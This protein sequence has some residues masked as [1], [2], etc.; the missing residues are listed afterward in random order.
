M[1]IKFALNLFVFLFA[2]NKLYAQN[3]GIGTTAPTNRVHV[4]SNLSNDLAISPAILVENINSS[5]GEAGVA[6]KNAGILGTNN[7]SWFIGL[8]Q[9]RNFA[10]SYGTAFLNSGTKMLLDSTGSLGLGTINPDNSAV[11]DLVSVDKGLLLPRLTDTDVV[12]VPTAGLVMYNQATKSP[13]YYDGT[14]WNNLNGGKNIVPLQGSITYTITGTTNVGGITVDAGPLAAIDYNNISFAARSSG[15]GASKAENVDS[16]IIFKEFDANSIV[17][18]RAHIGGNVLQVM[19]ISQFLPGAATP[20]Y[21]VKLTSFTVKSH[22]YFISET[23]G[24][25]TEKYGLVATTIGFKDWINN[26]S[27][28]INVSTQ[29][30][31]A[32]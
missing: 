11:L 13:N 1:K 10:W 28:S 14:K 20:F 3:V 7:K 4:V 16:I 25:L 2:V 8:N 24:K 15:L 22:S 26:K 23:T 18:K 5:T 27:F 12:V 31:G 6:F 9:N 21:S 19:E 29:A 32:Y 30:F 17:L